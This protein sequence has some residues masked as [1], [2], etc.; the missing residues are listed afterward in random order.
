MTKIAIIGAGGYEFP[1]QL[2]NDFLSFPSLQDAHF[3]L[4][5]IDPAALRPHRAARPRGWSRRTACRHGSSRPPTAGRRSRSRLRRRL[6]PGRRSGRL[7]GRH[8]DP[9]P[10]RRRPDRRRHARPG[11]RLPRPALDERRCEEITRDMRELCPDALLLNYANPMAINC[12][13]AA[14]QGVRTVGLCHS[15]QHTADELAAIMGLERRAPGRSARPGSTT[16]PGCW[17]SAYRGR[18]VLR[19][20]P[21]CGQRLP[22]GRARRRATP[23]RRVVRRRPGERAYRDHEPDRPLP[24]RVQPPRLGVLP[25]LPADARRTWPRCSRS[26]GT[27]WRS[28][29]ATTRRS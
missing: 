20:A 22:P 18:D 25:A 16:R 29:G 21:R 26:A 19:R 9:A 5:D 11:R 13:Y 7:R 4:M 28:P 10:V 27:T 6:L 23:D 24:D 1:L 12:W 17:T 14:G 2:M 15:V 8:G 3:A